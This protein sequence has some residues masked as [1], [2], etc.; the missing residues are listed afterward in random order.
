MPQHGI[1]DPLL[2][3]TSCRC[4]QRGASL[5]LNKRETRFQV[6]AYKSSYI[7]LSKEPEHIFFTKI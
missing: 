6:E 1:F 7:K 4:K 5:A 2:R 3:Y